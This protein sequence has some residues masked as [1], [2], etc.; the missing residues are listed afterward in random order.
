MVEAA[1]QALAASL[2]LDPS[3]LGGE[4]FA[5]FRGWLVLMDVDVD[6]GWWMVVGRF[7]V[8]WFVFLGGKQFLVGLVG[9]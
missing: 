5:F 2:N 4:F 9:W 3:A 7:G 8:E 6:G 1:T